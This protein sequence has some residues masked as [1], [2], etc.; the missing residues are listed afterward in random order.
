MNIVSEK[1]E[2]PEVGVMSLRKQFY[3]LIKN[4]LNQGIKDT[5]IFFND[6]EKYNYQ[7]PQTLCDV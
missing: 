5:I 4:R 3:F 6:N 7:K 1:Q 2:C